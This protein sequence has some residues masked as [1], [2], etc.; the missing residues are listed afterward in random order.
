MT[1]LGKVVV[2][3]VVVVPGVSAHGAT[4]ATVAPGTGT[5][6][7]VALHK[8]SG[9]IVELVDEVDDDVVVALA[10][11]GAPVSTNSAT[12]TALT[13]RKRRIHHT[14]VSNEVSYWAICQRY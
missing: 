14:L 1:A 13:D 6:V 3:V 2:V 5:T 9:A 7:V 8:M 10:T 11:M 12:T 4:G